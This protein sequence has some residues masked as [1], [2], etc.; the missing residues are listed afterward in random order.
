VGL[1]LLSA[2]LA[3]GGLGP[4]TV[5]TYEPRP[6][7]RSNGETVETLY[8]LPGV[9]YGTGAPLR[10]TREA[11]A[12]GTVERDAEAVAPAVRNLTRYRFVA[13][14]LADRYYRVDA[15]TE[16]GRFV[17]DAARADTA[18]VVDAFAVAPDE[19]PRPIRRAFADGPLTS[20][21]R[22]NTTLVGGSGDTTLVVRTESER[23]SDPLAVPKVASLAL[24][25]ALL[26]GGLLGVRGERA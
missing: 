21:R 13:D 25:V 22:V 10:L 4:Q 26:L 3:A 7:D 16:E 20:P 15:R 14:D 24:G 8:D 9:A 11:A 23:A 2:P 17:L 12:N 18:A 6:V 1:A 5:Y 19:A